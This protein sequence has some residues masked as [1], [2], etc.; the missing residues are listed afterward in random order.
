MHPSMP[1]T[2]PHVAVRSLLPERR[3]ERGFTLLE[4]MIAMILFAVAAGI[5]TMALISAIGGSGSARSGAVSDASIE[6]TTAAFRDDVA[7]AIT[8][9]R[10]N[11]RLREPADFSEAVMLN[12][13]AYSTD[14]SD[15][16]GTQLDIDDI[17]AASPR[18]LKLR[19]DTVQSVAGSECVSWYAQL[20]GTA[21]S[22]ER[23][24]DPSTACASSTTPGPGSLGKRVYLKADTRVSGV[25]VNPFSF[26]LVCRQGAC[27]G[28]AAP[29]AAPCRPWRVTDASTHRRWVVGVHASLVAASVSGDSASR[30]ESSATSVIRSRDTA[31]YRGALGC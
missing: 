24:I 14:P 5:V 13:P 16:P 19:S 3:D 17:T 4:L 1:R 9:D 26:D 30:S 18:L 12:T 7:R 10:A 25:D 21:F 31:T 6:R 27:P 2:V 28:S 11:F 8:P 20:V 23:R 22:I 15:P 29:A